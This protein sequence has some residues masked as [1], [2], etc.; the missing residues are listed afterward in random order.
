MTKIDIE[1]IKVLRDRTGVSIMQCKKALEESEG[2]I[3]KSVVLLRKRS[4][5]IAQKKAGLAREL[6]QVTYMMVS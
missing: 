5:A 4:G 6:L 1:T 2:D 3:E